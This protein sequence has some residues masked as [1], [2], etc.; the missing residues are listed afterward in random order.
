MN[1][2]MGKIFLLS[3]KYWIK[4]EHFIAER[5]ARQGDVPGVP[6]KK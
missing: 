6:P 3:E 1:I 5:K 4:L 2:R